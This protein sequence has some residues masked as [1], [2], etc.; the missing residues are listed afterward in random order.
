VKHEYDFYISSLNLIVEFDGDY[1]HGNP[2]LFELD[3]RMKQQYRIDESWTEKAKVGG[4]YLTRV[5]ASS[6]QSSDAREEW[7][8]GVMNEFGS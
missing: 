3:A 6:M 5:W 1:W 8:Q 7:L 2:A 4:Y